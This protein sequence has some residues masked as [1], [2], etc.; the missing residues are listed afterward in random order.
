MK[1][2]TVR[3][4]MTHRITANFWSITSQRAICNN[5]L[6]MRR[7]WYVVCEDLYIKM[8]INIKCLATELFY[9]NKV[10]VFLFIFLLN[11]VR[12]YGSK[13]KFETARGKN[14][15]FNTK[16][17]TKIT[18]NIVT[19]EWKNLYAVN[20]MFCAVKNIPCTW[21]LNCVLLCGPR[22]IIIVY[23][24]HLPMVQCWIII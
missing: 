8:H 1:F 7:L 22:H 20:F 6:C 19:Y 14:C 16:Y 12:N 4:T 3:A 10:G 13:I 15:I 2:Y 18:I 5:Q 17:L 24:T 9:S 23:S 11:L 21:H